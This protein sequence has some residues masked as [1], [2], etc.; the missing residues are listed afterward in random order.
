MGLR[1]GA[2]LSDCNVRPWRVG[3]L[4]G[5]TIAGS[6]LY[7][8]AFLAGGAVILGMYAAVLYDRHLKLQRNQMYI[9]GFIRAIELA[10]QVGNTARRRRSDT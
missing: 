10:L 4:F 3:L 9:D 6:H 1:R 8:H 5:M 2:I 7:G